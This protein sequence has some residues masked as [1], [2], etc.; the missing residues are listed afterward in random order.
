MERNPA[1]KNY[2]SRRFVEAFGNRCTDYKDYF[3][4]SR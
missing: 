4:T 2:H 1:T 3:D